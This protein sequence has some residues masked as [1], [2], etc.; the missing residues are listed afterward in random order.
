MKKNV[1]DPQTKNKWTKKD[2]IIMSILGAFIIGAGA[3]TG[4]LIG[5]NVF[6]QGEVNYSDF[7]ET[8][9]EDNR[10]KFV[11]RFNSTS[12]NDYTNIFKPNELV[13]IAYQKFSNYEK[14]FQATTGTV[15]AVGFEQSVASSGMKVGSNYFA[16]SFSTGF[17]NVGKRY[18]FDGDN[19]TS[20]YTGSNPQTYSASWSEDAKEVLDNE[21]MEK[22]WGKLISRPSIYLLCSKTCLNT[23]TAKKNS[24]GTYTVEIDLDTT[25][26]VSRYVR[27]MCSMSGLSKNPR[28]HSIHLNYTLSSELDLIQVNTKEN[29]DVF[30][31]FWINT[32][33][34]LT[35]KFVINGDNVI[36]TINENVSYN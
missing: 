25:Y 2:T 18:Y 9:W 28:F 14:T 1:K 30:K 16:E 11:E 31:G 26:S 35:E 5:N 24:D 13:G 33:G 17:I 6:D 10:A 20:V 27:Q 8:K 29:Y 32:T 34:D 23:S 21:Q 15:I 3:L 4:I 22:T 12:T 7:D 19:S 36:P